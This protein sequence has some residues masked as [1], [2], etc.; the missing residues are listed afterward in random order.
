M[1]VDLTRAQATSALGDRRAGIAILT[2]AANRL[3]EADDVP[4]RAPSRLVRDLMAVGENQLARGVVTYLLKKAEDRFY[5][6]FAETSLP[7]LVGLLHDVGADAQIPDVLAR[8]AKSSC[9]EDCRRPGGSYFCAEADQLNE[10]LAEARLSTGDVAGAVQVAD[11]LPASA[12]RDRLD[13]TLIELAPALKQGLP[14]VDRLRRMGD[15][16]YTR[17]AWGTVIAR[18]GA[19]GE[20][21]RALALAHECPDAEAKVEALTSLAKIASVDMQPDMLGEAVREVPRDGPTWLEARLLAR[22]ACQATALGLDSDLRVL[23]ALR[24]PS[25]AAN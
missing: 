3:M 6:R 14:A 11:S 15:T 7:G 9:F 4:L 21:A 10:Q 22:V 19:D 2:V 25:D 16:A 18:E 1:R 24:D 12:D 8:A 23:S 17:S 20:L 5:P 13:L